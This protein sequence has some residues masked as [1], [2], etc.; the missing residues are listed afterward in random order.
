MLWEPCYT[1]TTMAATTQEVARA[2]NS[3][4]RFSSEDQERM[5]E[6]IGDFFLPILLTLQYMILKRILVMT[7]RWKLRQV[8][9]ASVLLHAKN[10]TV[11]KYSPAPWNDGIWVYS[12]YR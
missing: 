11:F 7:R 12:G 5:L 6:V 8:I 4:L 3:L 1:V 9:K 2:I 10:A